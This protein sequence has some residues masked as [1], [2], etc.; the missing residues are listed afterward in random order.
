MSNKKDTLL[1]IFSNHQQSLKAE[2][3]RILSVS[4]ENVSQFPL[5][6]AVFEYLHEYCVSGKLFRGCL[7]LS[8]FETVADKKVY[9]YSELLT[10]AAAIELY[11][12]GILIQDDVMDQDE[13]R[14]GKQTVHTWL[15][16]YAQQHQIRE[17]KRWGESIAI[18]FSDVLFFIAG[19][20]ITTAQLPAKKKLQIASYSHKELTLL[21]LAQA[22]DIRQAQTPIFPSQEEILQMF[23][24]KTGRYTARWPL[25]VAAVLADLSS[26]QLEK[27]E[28]IGEELGVLYQMRD[29]YLGLFGDPESTGKNVLSD[30]REGKKTLYAQLFFTSVPKDVQAKALI[31]FGNH[32]ATDE[33]CAWFAS[34]VQHYGVEQE[35]HKLI[36]A[37]TTTLVNA[38]HQ[39]N[40]PQA[41][42]LLLK[43]LTKYVL[44][45]NK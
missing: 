12:S 8:F 20:L 5:D 19:Q 39:S 43:S 44:T 25:A 10:I 31:I 17:P 11:G 26:F 13:R 15:A 24:G 14:R 2:I 3:Q 32:A 45:R 1:D 28:K 27:V 21:G 41:S 29:D 6:A 35:V 40:L 37:H 9:A 4:S 36:K 22:E 23:L 7:F 30:I 38:V 33:D 34:A 16:Q 42:Q 18:C